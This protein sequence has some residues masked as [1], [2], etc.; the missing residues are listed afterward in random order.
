MNQVNESSFAGKAKITTNPGFGGHVVFDNAA[1]AQV[2]TLYLDV[3]SPHAVE[4]STACQCDFSIRATRSSPDAIG[5]G[6]AIWSAASLYSD[7]DGNLFLGDVVAGV[8]AIE[9]TCTKDG[10]ADA[11]EVASIGGVAEVRA[12][13][14]V[15]V[16]SGETALFAV[17]RTEMTVDP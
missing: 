15:A 7:R 1:G 5:K 4:I 16:T 3:A 12:Q 11:G 9:I 2:K 17:T 14:I 8:T 13:K 6:T 10:V